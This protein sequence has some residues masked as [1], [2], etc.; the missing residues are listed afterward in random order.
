MTIR[1]TPT[2]L[3]AGLRTAFCSLAAAV[4]FIAAPHAGA[5]A[6]ETNLAL[7]SQASFDPDMAAS[8][9][10]TLVVA[11]PNPRSKVVERPQVTVVVDLSEQRMTVALEDQVLHSWPVSTGRRGHW[12]PPGDFDVQFLSPYHR[13]SIYNNA[14]MPWSIFFNGDIAIHG[15]TAVSRLGRPAS[16]GCV[17]LRTSNARA[18]FDLV[19]DVGAENVSISVVR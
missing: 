2:G 14:P 1:R 17:R 12:T 15:T 19:V 6:R 18:L 8:L 10:P 4:A 13:S 5:E 9:D 7:A 3:V 11:A 16:H